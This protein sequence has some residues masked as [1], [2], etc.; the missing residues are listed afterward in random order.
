MRIHFTNKA[1]DLLAGTISVLIFGMFLS[2]LLFLFEHEYT[3]IGQN[4]TGGISLA[5]IIRIIIFFN[6]NR[7]KE[8][9]QK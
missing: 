9:N 2:V 4:I 1:L 5:F 6:D 8:K 7:K 3:T